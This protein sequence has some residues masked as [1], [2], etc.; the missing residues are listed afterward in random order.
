MIDL[1]FVKWA[2]EYF[3]YFRFNVK[4]DRYDVYIDYCKNV[5]MIPAHIF[6]EKINAFFE[7]ANVLNK[8]VSVEVNPKEMSD[9]FGRFVYSDQNNL[10]KSFI[11]LKTIPKN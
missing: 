8:S 4:L 11:Y 7:I 1:K 6:M 5:E 2:S 9:K 10:I 3:K